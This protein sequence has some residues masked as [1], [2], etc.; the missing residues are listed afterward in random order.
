MQTVKFNSQLF[1]GPLMLSDPLDKRLFRALA[2]VVQGS[3]SFSVVVEDLHGRIAVDAHLGAQV[4]VTFFR[5]VK[6]QDGDFVLQ[7]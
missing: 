5:A 7:F 1:V 3:L 4:V 6:R 2:R